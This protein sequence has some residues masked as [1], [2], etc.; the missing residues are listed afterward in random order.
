MYY[1][2]Q[3][4]PELVE[5]ERL[6]SAF[7]DTIELQVMCEV[8]TGPRKF[9]VYAIALGN[10]A[11]SVPAVGYFGGVHG[12]ERIGSA[13]VLA[14]LRSV[15][16]RLR[17]D[18]TLHHQLE[19]LRMV[20]MPVVNPGGLARGARAN[21]AGVDLMRNAPLDARDP[22]PFLLGGQRLSP[23]LPWYRGRKGD[24]MQPESQALCRVVES[25][26]LS[27]AF[28]IA[29]DCHSGFGT[30]DRIWFPYASTRLPIAHLPEMHALAEIL[31][32]THLHHPY[33]FEPQSS[34]YLTH[35]DLWDY[36]YQRACLEPGCV[37]LPLTLEMGSWLC[38]KKNPRQM[39]SL[40]GFFN[41]L[42]AHRHARVLR[43]HIHWL[44]F[45]G[46]AACGHGGWVPTGPER[47]RHRE[48][49]LRRWY[50]SGGFT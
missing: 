21:P 2:E 15:I 20:F 18:E 23:W 29:V 8:S 32:Q 1:G 17:W 47:A 12:V 14:F 38:V 42:I 24:A 48:L 9:P 6:I 49:A 36:L 44:E 45:I 50:D 46:R 11:P 30:C 26:L 35:G 22:V 19:H 13:V 43:R 41:P 33:L 3:E 40:L 25:E 39:L 7:G 34:Q 5:L 4:P 37:H 16:M 27:H 28:S 31:D 10:P